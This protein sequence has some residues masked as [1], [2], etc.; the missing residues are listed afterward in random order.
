MQINPPSLISFLRTPGDMPPMV[1]FEDSD[2]E[3]EEDAASA[4]AVIPT[5]VALLTPPIFPP[6]VLDYW[7][8]SPPK[9]RQI[10]TPSAASI[11]LH[12]ADN[13]FLSPA[14]DDTHSNLNRTQISLNNT[15]RS[16]GNIEASQRRHVDGANAK[17]IQCLASEIENDD[18]SIILNDVLLKEL[19]PSHP[20]LQTN[21]RLLP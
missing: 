18:T 13:M 5:S 20:L 19:F 6:A 14:T 21:E 8:R 7:R 9:E 17:A 1:P 16:H 3:D 10:S 4:A 2:D 11:F 15:V 12:S